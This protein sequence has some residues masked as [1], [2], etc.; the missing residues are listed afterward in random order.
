MPRVNEDD[1]DW[2]ETEAGETTFRRK[3]LGSA[4]GATRLGASLYELPPG[5]SSWP[6]HFHTGNEE[7]AYVL[8]GEG[9]LRTP[10]GEESIRAGD[11][12]SFPADPSGAH[13]LRNDGDEPLRY[14]MVS[15]MRD[16]DVTVYPDSEKIG[17]Y[18]GSP[19]G[20]EDERVVSG[21]FERDETVDYWDDEP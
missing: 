5:K 8:A 3:K 12:L 16:P 18:A 17:V 20:G 1:V 11:L 15:T 21:Y 6:Y 7:M 2:T 14:L 13:K 9:T 10:D 4:A 19:P